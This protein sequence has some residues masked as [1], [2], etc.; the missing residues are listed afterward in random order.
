ME[1]DFCQSLQDYFQK[2]NSNL[3][4]IEKAI[5]ITSYF[6]GALI[7]LKNAKKKYYIWTKS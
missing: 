6:N 1:M 5:L 2:E 4:I 3:K 7:L